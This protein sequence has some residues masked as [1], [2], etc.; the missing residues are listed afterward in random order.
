[1]LVSWVYGV[2][3][4]FSGIGDGEEGVDLG[5]IGWIRSEEV[6]IVKN[7]VLIFDLD[8]RVDEIII[9]RDVEYW[10]SKFLRVEDILVWDIY[11]K[12]CGV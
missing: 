6:S 12:K 10:S 9:Y 5:L 3:W 1:M 2:Y 11:K 7:V 4:E 8:Y